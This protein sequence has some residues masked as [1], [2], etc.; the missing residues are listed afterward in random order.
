M[1]GRDVLATTTAPTAFIAGVTFYLIAVGEGIMT[2]EPALAF[3]PLLF[4][5]WLRLC[6]RA[7]LTA[8]H[9]MLARYVDQEDPR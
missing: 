1:A 7:D 2:V 5:A 3:V 9:E 8:W 4:D 6:H